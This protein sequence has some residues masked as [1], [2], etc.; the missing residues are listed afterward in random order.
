V[1]RFITAIAATALVVASS[2]LVSVPAHARTSVATCDGLNAT[3]VGTSGDDALTGTP[4]NDVIVGLAG[5]DVIDGGGGYDVICGGQGDDT[6]TS[7]P[8]NGDVV[9]VGGSGDDQL[10]SEAKRTTIDGGGGDD[11]EVTDSKVVRYVPERG[12]NHLSTSGFTHVNADFSQLTSG[13]HADLHTGAITFDHGSTTV[14]IPTYGTRW[15]VIGTRFPDVIH[16]S[17]F[18]DIIHG[19]AADDVIRGGLGADRLNGGPGVDILRGGWGADDLMIRPTD[20]VYGG[21]GDDYF[22]GLVALGGS[23][24][25]HGGPGAN[26]VGLRVTGIS[27]DGSVYRHVLVDL[28][29]E[30]IVGDGRVTRLLGTF[31]SASVSGHVAAWTLLGNGDHNYLAAP[32]PA[33]IR[34]RGGD[35]IL[36]S[37]DG[38]DQLYGGRGHDLADARGGRD[39]CASIEGPLP[40]HGSTGCD[41]SH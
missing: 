16:G 34:A 23:A 24:P 2:M 37:G 3:I 1:N 38:P 29:N 40:S 5:S 22:I 7:P 12:T 8:F 17:D 9:L 21:P 28:A 33:L 13:L 26:H 15:T 39:L 6:L 4:G 35:D 20:H 41:S 18:N 31:D 25:I 27:T 36:I 19:G 32:S 30:R 11:V 10:K 14:A